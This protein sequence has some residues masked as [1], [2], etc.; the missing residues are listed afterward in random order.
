MSGHRQQPSEALPLPVFAAFNSR[1]SKASKNVNTDWQL[2][3]WIKKQ[4]EYLRNCARQ[5]R[6]KLNLKILCSTETEK[7]LTSK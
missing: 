6:S 1:K 7:S 2:R 4:A 3:G 5:K